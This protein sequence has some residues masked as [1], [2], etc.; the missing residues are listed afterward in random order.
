MFMSVLSKIISP[1]K[2]VF[3]RLWILCSLKFKKKPLMG[4]GYL[5]HLMPPEM[6]VFKNEISADPQGTLNYCK[7]Y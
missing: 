4:L 5:F 7:P 2:N 3:K 1:K 6:C